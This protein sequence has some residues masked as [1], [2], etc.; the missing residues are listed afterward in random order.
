MQHV[1]E[2]M[3]KDCSFLLFLSGWPEHCTGLV[4]MQGK[5]LCPEQGHEAATGCVGLEREKGSLAM[6]SPRDGPSQIR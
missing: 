5:M 1:S 3:L 6:K 4:G 2:L